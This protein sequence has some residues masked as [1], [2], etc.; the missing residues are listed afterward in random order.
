MKAIKTLLSRLIFG[1]CLTT[2]VAVSAAYP[3]LPQPIKQGGGA[4]IGDMLYVGLGTAGDKFYRLSLQA[5]E[6]K[7]KWQPIADFP[8]GERIQPIVAVLDQQLY[9]FGGQQSNEQGVRQFI[10]DV[11]RYDPQQDRWVKLNAEAPRGLAGGGAV[12]HN[13][14]IYLLGGAN[15]SLLNGYLQDYAVASD[16][17][18]RQV[19]DEAFFQKRPQDY[20]FTNELLSYTPYSNQW[21]NEGKIPFE[22]RIGAAVLGQGET[23]LVVSGEIKPGLTSA[24]TAQGRLSAQGVSWKALP[25]LPTLRGKSQE[26]IAWAGVGYSHGYYLIVGGAN[27]PGAQAQF[28]AGELFAHQSLAKVQQ[29]E[30]YALKNGRWK[31]I[32]ELTNPVSGAVSVSYHNQ[33]LLIGGENENGKAL[34]TIQVLE[35]DGSKLMIE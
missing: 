4:L 6:S 12:T 2:A 10:N 3:D 32:G 7:A 30:I 26:G 15:L 34:S 20:F 29:K 16:P 19:V 9:V 35:Y 22:P 18:Q 14:K 33:V 5:A 23:L 17:A 24:T 21:R 11:H 27:F 31:M 1:L 13:G 25:N 28:A 8:G